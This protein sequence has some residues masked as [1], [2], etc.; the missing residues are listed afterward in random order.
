MKNIYDQMVFILVNKYL[1]LTMNLC[2]FFKK[3]VLINKQFV[4][5]L[6]DVRE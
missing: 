3:Y 5:G 1:I 4:M 6:C 2:D